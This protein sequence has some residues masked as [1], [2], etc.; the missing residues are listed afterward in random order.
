ME[1][2]LPKA[3]EIRSTRAKYP[4]RLKGCLKHCQVKGSKPDGHLII[5]LLI[6]RLEAHVQQLTELSIDD[7]RGGLYG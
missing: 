2:T 6:K 7:V 4:K 3:Y 5:G 1:C